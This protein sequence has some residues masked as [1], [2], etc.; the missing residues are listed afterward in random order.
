M[1]LGFVEYK[2]KVL[3]EYDALVQIS[4]MDEEYYRYTFSNNPKKQRNLSGRGVRESV[5]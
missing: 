4:I 2:F 3:F 1:L 5:L